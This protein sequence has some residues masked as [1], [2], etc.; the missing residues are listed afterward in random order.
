MKKQSLLLLTV[1]LL[2]SMSGQAKVNVVYIMADDLGWADISYHGGDIPTPHIDSFFAG[3]VELKNFMTWSVCSPTRAG[4]LTGIHPIMT[5]QAPIV[6]GELKGEL[7]TI[8]ESFKSNGY[9]TGAFGKWHNNEPQFRDAAGNT[10]PTPADFSRKPGNFIVN[11]HG[12]DEWAGFYAGGAD[13][14]T[15]VANGTPQWFHNQLY[16]PSVWNTDPKYKGDKTGYITDMIAN[17]ATKFIDSAHQ[18]GKPFFCYIPFNA[19]HSPRTFKDAA[20][21]DPRIPAGRTTVDSRMYAEMIILLDD[22]VGKVLAKLDALG[23]KNNTIVVFTSDN[24]GDVDNGANNK[25]F[26]QGKHT[27]WEGGIHVATAIRWPGGGLSGTNSSAKYDGLMGYLDMYPTLAAMCGVPRLP[28]P[29]HTLDGYN[30]WP[31]LQARTTPTPVPFYIS[32]SRGMDVLRTPTHKYVLDYRVS[33]NEKLFSMVADI[34]EKT[35]IKG[36][37]LSTFNSLKQTAKDWW[38]SRGVNLTHVVPHQ[39]VGLPA[40][41]GSVLKVTITK[42]TAS[43]SSDFWMRFST[44]SQTARKGDYLEYDIYIPAA[45]SALN[46]NVTLA[47]DTS[48]G[49]SLGANDLLSSNFAMDQETNVYN[50]IK[51]TSYKKAQGQWGRYRIGLASLAPVTSGKPHIVL[52]KNSP[53]GT[54]EMYIDNV[55]MRGEAPRGLICWDEASDL[56]VVRKTDSNVT[57][58]TEVVNLSTLNLNASRFMS[59]TVPDRVAPGAQFT[60]QVTFGN[61]GSSTWTSGDGMKLGSLND[62]ATWGFTRVNLP[63]SVAPG[64]T[65]SFPLTITAPSVAGNY[66]F[67]WRM[68]DEAGSNTGWF[69]ATSTLKTVTV[70]NGGTTT[71]STNFISVA[72][73]DGYVDE[74][75]ETSNVGGTNNAGFTDGRAL[76]VGDTGGKRQRKSIV[77]FDTSALPDSAVITAA[78]LKLKCGF[79]T[80][81]P[82]STLGTMAVDIKNTST[83]FSNSLALQNGDFE[84]AASASS[85][86]T[87]SN[88]SGV[89]VWSTASLNTNG[90]SR[91]AKTNSTQFRIRFT[92]DDDNDSSDDYLG[93]YSGEA[94]TAGDRPVLARSD[95]SVILT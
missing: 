71:K 22:A 35:D 94:A 43:L 32:T 54:Y 28:D 36:S 49:S 75:S 74:S 3:A 87:L 4:L 53:A 91:I 41:S 9:T 45:H 69:G 55:V 63:G 52:D 51:S 70:T 14:L 40:P 16:V 2:L 73:H 6:D 62:S 60:A 95:L 72:A 26:A 19:P 8:A 21:P 89:G 76:R 80:N 18:A 37:N 42:K 64:Q 81:A 17:Y 50:N 46:A 83:G 90:T 67:Q 66:P 12:F 57:V 27:D 13:Y 47:K 30:V 24:G 56:S 68:V 23:I 15:K 10:L 65:V 79:I 34:G 48:T 84:A 77:S 93:F 1:A 82:A 58:V 88:P 11:D 59:V 31:A 25:P 39:T 20:H 5:D 7:I 29:N 86:G 85:V 61:T 38:N 44:K 33:T 92:T 78:T